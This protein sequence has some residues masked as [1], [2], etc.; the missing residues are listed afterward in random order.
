MIRLVLVSLW[1]CGV[2][3]TTSYAGMMWQRGR[4]SEAAKVEERPSVEQIKVRKITVPFISEG[5]VHGYVIA[6]LTAILRAK[7]HKSQQV[8]PE[9]IIVDE[10]FRVLYAN[11]SVDFRKPKAGDTSAIARQ[12]AEG[13]NKRIGAQLVSEILLEELSYVPR[14]EIRAG[15]R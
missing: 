13:V 12:I 3:V 5:A 2:V 6:Q 9:A 1:M 7:E 15:P 11:E 10:A 4:S 8:K 14:S